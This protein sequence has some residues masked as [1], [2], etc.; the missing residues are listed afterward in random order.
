[1]EWSSL[2][3]IVRELVSNVIAHAKASQAHIYL[4]LEEGQLFISCTDDGQGK[5]PST[6]SR[7]LGVGGI[8]KRVRLLG[9]EVQ[10]REHTP[11]GI[12]CDVYIPRLAGCIAPPP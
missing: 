11:Q 12:V 8:R 9:G 1:V 7:G 2:T 3:R 10:W 4:R 5:D 6:W